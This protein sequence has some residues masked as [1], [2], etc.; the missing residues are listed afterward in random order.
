MRQHDRSSSE[1]LFWPV[2]WAVGLHAILFAFLF[3]SFARTPDLP[4]ARP[5]I[6]A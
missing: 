2:V 5:V 4:P 6:K 1:N 3:V